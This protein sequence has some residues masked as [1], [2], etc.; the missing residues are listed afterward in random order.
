MI[1]LYTLPGF[2]FNLPSL[3]V[4]L[5]KGYLEEN[6]ILSHQY[7]LSISF[8]E[9]CVNSSYIKT[10]YKDYHKSLNKKEKDVINNIHIDI[11]H[12]KSKKINTK[13]IIKSNEN[14]LRFLNIYSNIFNI[15][16]SYKGL[17]FDSKIK[18]IDDLLKFSFNN[19][20]KIFDCVLKISNNKAKIN[21][22][23]V[24][25]PFQLPY[26]LRLAKYIKK[27]NSDSKVILGGDYITH[28][29]KNAEELITKCDYIDA[30][31]FFGEYKYLIELIDFYTQNKR[32]N[33]KNTIIRNNE[34]LIINEIEK[35]D[36]YTKN[37][38]VPSF[39]DLDLN[40]YI[41]NLKLV[42]LTLSYGC[43]HS[44]CKFCSRYF[45][46]NGYAK[47]DINKIFNLI[48]KL[49]Y[50]EEI[51]AI[52]FI[53]ECVPPNIL[54]ELANFLI[55]NEIKIKW[56]VET[57]IDKE[58]EN[59][60]V[61]EL[62]YKSGC[63]EISFG[64][65]SYNKKILK[66]MNKQ[67]DLKVAKKVMKNFFE[68]GICVSATFMI[69]YPTESIFNILRTLCFI[70]KFK[71]LDTFGL[72]VFHYMRNSILVNN[73]NLNEKEDLN[74]IYRKYNDNYDFYNNLIEKFNLNS[75]IKKFVKIRKKVLYRSE[76]LYLDRKEY[77]LNYKG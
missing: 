54:K 56:M 47:Y 70:K 38:Y 1:N 44:K 20:N 59:K 67:I 29:I 14:L 66:D 24:Q 26:A 40:K 7:D 45:Y 46:Y 33:I 39:K 8:F 31:L 51:E 30:I 55:E 58:L 63:R 50:E 15:S 27:S 42:S 9:K 10:K 75:K 5:I 4:P 77:S 68:S 76:Y 11:K 53:D 61:S 18:T 22:I 36:K 74:L 13:R 28:I 64:I 2:A 57:R 71:Y 16:W 23:S 6:N 17:E 52:Y 69:G 65:E 43:Y 32:N 19:K 72:G 35:C 49:Y 34:K 21:Y 12:L 37:M 62:L 48:K 3:S 73:S 25:Y 41:S 60:E